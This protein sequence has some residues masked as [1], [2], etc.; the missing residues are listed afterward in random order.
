MVNRI[1]RANVKRIALIASSLVILAGA[2]IYLIADI[3]AQ[4][5]E[6]TYIEEFIEQNSRYI[7]KIAGLRTEVTQLEGRLKALKASI[8][9]FPSDALVFADVQSKVSSLAKEMGVSVDSVRLMKSREASGGLWESEIYIAVYGDSR[10]VLEF[11]ERLKRKLKGL[12]FKE[13]SF[14]TTKRYVNKKSVDVLKASFKVVQIWRR[15]KP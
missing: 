11:M 15:K 10:S 3:K 12:K 8:P 7:S 4:R 13:V 6:L 14:I 2:Y 1:K 5:E 9:V